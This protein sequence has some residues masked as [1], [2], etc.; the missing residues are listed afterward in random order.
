MINYTSEYKLLT[1]SFSRFL[2]PSIISIL[3]CQIAPFVD[4]LCVSAKVGEAALSAIG[5]ITPI[6]YILNIPA[7]LGGIGGG[8]MISYLSASGHKE[9]TGRVFT[10][11][12][13][14]MIISG[15]ALFIVGTIFINPFTRFLGGVSAN[16]DYALDYFKILLIDSPFYVICFAGTYL[17]VND[18]A[19]NLSM[20]GMIVSNVVN[21][22]IDVVFVV[23]LDKGIKAAAWGT[24]I[25]QIAGCAVYA[26]HFLR[27]ERLCRFDFS[28]AKAKISLR[29]IIQNGTP[30]ALKYFLFF[31]QLF[32]A[33][34]LMQKYY[35]VAGLADATIIANLLLI[36]TIFVEGISESV[37]PLTAAL[38]GEK[39]KVGI[40]MVKKIASRFSYLIIIPLTLSV[41]IYP[42]W[43]PRL[44]SITDP[45]VLAAMPM[46]LRIT[47]L[48]FLFMSLNL[49]IINSCV[50]DGKSRTA[51]WAVVIR[52]LVLQIPLSFLIA[53][54]DKENAPWIASLIAEVGCFFYL[55]V[56][57]KEYK[58][59]FKFQK[60]N[61][62]YL[63]GGKLTSEN[64][65]QWKKDL[66]S[67][68]E[69][70]YFR[71]A[72]KAIFLPL[73]NTLNDGN[74]FTVSF[75]LLNLGGGNK[76]LILLFDKKTDMLYPSLKNG[77]EVQ[78]E[79]SLNRRMFTMTQKEIDAENKCV[80]IVAPECY[81]GKR[82]V[83]CAHESG[84]RVVLCVAAP[85]AQYE[86]MKDMLMIDE[87][88]KEKLCDRVIVKETFQELLDEL[89]K[90]ERNIIASIPGSEFSVETAERLSK[91][92][93]VLGN[94]PETT[95]WRRNKFEMKQ[96]I[97]RAGLDHARGGKFSK[98]EDA[99]SFVDKNLEYPI[100]IKPPAGAGSQNVFK[101]KSRDE[102]IEKFNIV[103]TTPD[104]YKKYADSVVVEEM[105][106]GDEYAVNIFGDD[107]KVVVTSIW[108]YIKITNEFAD[109]LYWNDILM[110][111]NDPQ[112]TELKDYAVKLYK[113]VG[114]SLGPGHAEI[115]LSKRG[116]I[117]IEIGARLMGSANETYTQIGTKIDSPLETLKV[118]KTGKSD[119]PENPVVYEYLGL[120]NL[121]FTQKGKI[122][123]I[124]GLDDIR[125][126]PSYFTEEM[127]IKIGDEI[128]PSVNLDMILCGIWL[129]SNSY[130]QL[131]KD[132]EKIHQLFQLE[133]I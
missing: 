6:F 4:S 72:D 106:D 130:K 98:I 44:F 104:D 56:I 61:A 28:F 69:E 67:I 68:I 30:E 13:F 90:T 79:C 46:S 115:K 116:P 110:D 111:I 71:L 123:A 10:K 60:A 22:I 5:I 59:L 14:F 113:A 17:L 53:M 16:M 128:E 105:I 76:N 29:E 25:G 100:F 78:E 88:V 97:A 96:A 91:A 54:V 117:A 103:L 34:Y 65:L 107:K 37:I 81:S 48:S 124:N 57:K 70:R 43:F 47:S 77:F 80:V 38:S 83:E 36:T 125:N 9:K 92:L 24:V 51:L 63:S 33:N 45:E 7:V 21:I 127:P 39:N 118:F 15:F 102:F 120:A 87:C 58:G 109:N 19:Q 40:F 64:L 108:K 3:F 23:V 89:K 121:P 12:F 112:F 52:I 32:T 73:E 119:V 55:T 31:V 35:G 114:I 20:A 94:N 66:Q 82:L 101:C 84:N 86:L 1:K 8:I 49:I 50:A 122:K 26:F 11:A 18:N 41:L 131:I 85:S 95:E 27:K 132:Q 2:I 129:R 42:M 99:L 133:V 126:L 74:T 93:G 62:E 75:S